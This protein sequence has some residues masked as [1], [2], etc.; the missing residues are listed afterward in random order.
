MAFEKKEITLLERFEKFAASK[1]EAKRVYNLAEKAL[2]GDMSAFELNGLSIFAGTRGFGEK[3]LFLIAQ[4]QID[5]L[6]G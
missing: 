1:S 3:A 5:I 2:D 6:K 4:V